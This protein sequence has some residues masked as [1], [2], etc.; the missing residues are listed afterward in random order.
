MKRVGITPSVEELL[1]SPQHVWILLHRLTNYFERLHDIISRV[2]KADMHS[3]LVQVLQFQ[4]NPS[5]ASPSLST[6]KH[7]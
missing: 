3:W 6:K 5:L 1:R 2:L 7:P 4:I